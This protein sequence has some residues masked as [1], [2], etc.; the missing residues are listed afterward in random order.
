[1]GSW[2]VYNSP[3]LCF[4]KMGKYADDSLSL[5]TDRVPNSPVTVIS[6]PLE[7]GSDSR[8][9]A[10]A[11]QYLF[12]NG[13][14]A[15]L[16]TLGVSMDQKLAISCPAGGQ[17]EGQL[18]SL[19]AIVAT[20]HES[21]KEVTRALKSGYVV[22][23]LGGDHAMAVGTVAGAVSATPSIGVVWIDA[24]PDV[25]TDKTTI[26][27]NI[28]GMPA[29]VAMGFGHPELVAV[30]GSAKV[31]PEDFLYLGVKDFD[32]AEVDFLQEKKVPVVTMFD[33][34]KF[35]LAPAVAAID[36][37]QRRV[38]SIWVSMD[39]D[40]IDKDYAPGV[41]M[42]THGGFTRREVV[43]LAHYIGRRCKVVGLDVVEMV[44]EKDEGGKTAQLALKLIGSFLGGDPGWYQDY[45]RGYGAG[46]AGT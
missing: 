22:V 26:S 30:G 17:N 12:D 41:A 44:P 36:D 37:L 1:M 40:S 8:G 25:H 39:M 38:D 28:H 32:Q 21:C 43:E 33:I 42:A 45:M 16:Q 7:L 23:A 11:P 31:A 27:G 13:L 14:E 24:H 18:K 46:P 5:Y 15:L 2:T 9:L 29:A 19:E 20:A 6:I 4:L 35:G 3:V 10:A 34:A